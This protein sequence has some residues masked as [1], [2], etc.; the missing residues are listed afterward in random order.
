MVR[1]RDG[2]LKNPE[3]NVPSRPKQDRIVFWIIINCA[4]YKPE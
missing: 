3:T 2:T 1:I 4:Y